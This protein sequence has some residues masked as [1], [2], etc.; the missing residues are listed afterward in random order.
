MPP[1]LSSVRRPGRRG[2]PNLLAAGSGFG[3]AGTALHDTLIPVTEPPL[4]DDEVRRTSSPDGDRGELD[5][6]EDD[7]DEADLDPEEFEM[8]A[9]RRKFQREQRAAWGSWKQDRELNRR[10]VKR[11]LVSLVVVAVLAGLLAYGCDAL[12]GP[13]QVRFADTVSGYRLEPPT[14]QT[15]QLAGQLQADGAIGPAA[16][17]YR[18]PG[19]VLLIAGYT[20][21]IPTDV[22]GGL[23]PPVTG[24]DNDYSGHGGPLTCGATAQGS[25]CVWKS[26]DL[27]GGTSA[28]G[29]PPEA[30][31]K[32]TRELRA[33]AIR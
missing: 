33:N 12:R 29:M 16:R 7:L 18:G 6:D 24:A 20:T 3:P 28:S 23:L 26:S 8:R 14:P 30:L 17:Y 22:V 27:V 32:I 2:C 11:S 5:P 15:D 13:R 31:E 9:A 10:K 21:D 4:D 1:P 25:R 19:E